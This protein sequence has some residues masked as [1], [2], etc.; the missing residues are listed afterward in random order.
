M[1]YYVYELI[2]LLGTVEYVG[3]TRNPKRRESQHT[4]DKPGHGNGSGKFYGRQDLIMNIVAEFPRRREALD[5]QDKLQKSYGFE[6][7]REK[8]GKAG[9]K[10]GKWAVESGH[11]KEIQKIGC[12]LGGKIAGMKKRKLTQSDAEEIRRLYIPRDKQFGQS[13][14]A[15]RY[16]VT[17]SI[18][19][20]IVNGKTYTS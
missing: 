1:K 16:G 19:Y 17:Q 10:G 7:D 2:N 6:T 5:L 20:Y 3:E 12:V 18:I 13:A 15:R 8:G 9:K 14:L 11:M 4:K